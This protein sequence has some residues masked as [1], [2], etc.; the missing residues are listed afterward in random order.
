MKKTAIALFALFASTAGLAG[1]E[2][3]PAPND[4]WRQIPANLVPQALARLSIGMPKRQVYQVLGAP[5]FDE[6]LRSHQWHYWY[7]G[8]ARQECILQVRYDRNM[9][10]ADLR[11]NAPAC[12]PIL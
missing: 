10:V 5:H 4:S 11:W 2:E 7:L 12:D 6:G 1:T 8:P 9:R 3:F